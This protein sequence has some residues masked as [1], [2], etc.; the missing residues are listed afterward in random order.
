MIIMHKVYTKLS[1]ENDEISSLKPFDVVKAVSM[2]DYWVL[3]SVFSR[4]IPV[5]SGDIF[6]EFQWILFVMLKKRR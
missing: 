2:S 5:L 1:E 4:R 3:S 6:C